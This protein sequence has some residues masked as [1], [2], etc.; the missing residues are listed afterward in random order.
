MKAFKRL[1][2]ILVALF[3]LTLTLPVY[4]AEAPEVASE[5]LAL[6]ASYESKAA[7]Q[8]AL[9]AEHTTMEQEYKERFFVNEKVT[10]IE[11]IR[12]M[13]NHCD[14]IIDAAQKEKNELLE[15]AQW[16]RMRAAEL[17]GL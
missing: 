7:A 17:Q 2:F 13:E 9:I 12:K 1:T 4:A 8:N 14:A 6:A 16:H 3:G 5:H 11:K 15:F 10:P